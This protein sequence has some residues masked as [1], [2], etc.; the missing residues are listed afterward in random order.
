M[1][2]LQRLLVC[3]IL[4]LFVNSDAISTTAWTDPTSGTKYDFSS[5][6]KDMK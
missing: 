1:K 4:I 2:L 6:K 3:A 5:L